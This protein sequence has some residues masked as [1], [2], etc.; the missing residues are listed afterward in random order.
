MLLTIQDRR[1]LYDAPSNETNPSVVMSIWHRNN[2]HRTKVDDQQ[3]CGLYEQQSVV[4]RCEYRYIM[5]LLQSDKHSNY[6]PILIICQTYSF[7]V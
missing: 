3:I 5:K 7:Y 2:I 4:N 6:P 1:S